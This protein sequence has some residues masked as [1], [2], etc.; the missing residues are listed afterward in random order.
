MIYNHNVLRTTPNTLGLPFHKG[1]KSLRKNLLSTGANTGAWTEREGAHGK[2]GPWKLE[3]EHH[4]IDMLRHGTQD[5][6]PRTPPVELYNLTITQRVKFKCPL[7]SSPS[8]TPT[9]LSSSEL[10]TPSTSTSTATGTIN[11]ATVEVTISTATKQVNQG[12]SM[13]SVTYPTTPWRI[14]TRK[15]GSWTLLSSHIHQESILCSEC[16]LWSYWDTVWYSHCDARRK[17]KACF[18]FES[19]SHQWPRG[20]RKH[21]FWG[22]KSIEAETQ[23]W[24]NS[25]L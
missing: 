11:E 8:P 7:S 14:P 3:P 20:S 4:G 17:A 23:I 15:L 2:A 22:K 25:H 5:I 19:H 1:S 6:V 9:P 24:R 16:S 12:S 13:I 18:D 10:G 21:Q